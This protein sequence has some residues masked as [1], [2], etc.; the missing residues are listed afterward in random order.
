VR[1]W[2]W[3]TGEV[4]DERQVTQ[5]APDH[6]NFTHDGSR[7]VV[8]EADGAVFSVDTQTLQRVGSILRLDEPLAS[9][10]VGPDDRSAMVLT[11][12]R[13]YALVDLVRSEVVR[14]GELGFGFSPNVS[15]DFSPDGRT[16]AAVGSNWLR[17][18]DVNSGEWLG[19]PLVAQRGQVYTATYAPDGSTFATGGADGT[20]SLWDGRTGDPRGS[21]LPGQRNVHVVPTYLPD[22]DTLQIASSEGDVYTWDTRP[23]QWVEFACQ[24]VGRNLTTEEWNAVFDDRP[25][26]KTCPDN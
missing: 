21:V 14:T 23:E 15:G 18:L 26:R 10:I 3:R 16:F 22:G 7:L 17:M 5:T 9:V 25:Y 19:P 1:L 24:V 12:D 8:G 20:V 2:D 11:Q 13:G 6:L 4:L